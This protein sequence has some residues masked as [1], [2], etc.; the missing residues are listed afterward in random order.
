MLK[1][2]YFIF[3]KKLFVLFII[4]VVAD[5]ALGNLLNYFFLKIKS[6]ETS[7][8]T[9]AINK[10]D[11]RLIVFGSSR[12]IHH[13]EPTVLE[14]S[15][16]LTVYNAG[17]DGQGILYCYGILKSI[18][19]RDTPQKI[20][21]DINL[22]EFIQSQNSYNRLSVLLPYYKTNREVRPVVNLKSRYEKI[23][24]F[25]SLYCYNSL[26][27]SIMLNNLI[28]RNETITKGYQPL[29]KILNKPLKEGDYSA[30]EGNIDTVKVNYFRYFIKDALSANC[31][32]HVFVSPIYY[33]NDSLDASIQIAKQ[34]CKQYNVQVSD[35]SQSPF[36]LK[37]PEY[38]QD[39]S[40][41]NNEGA[42][43]YSSMVS[44][45]IRRQTEI[46]H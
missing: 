2:P 42:K 4:L 28:Q 5:N 16:K 3:F 36:F 37:H 43:I 34:I 6:G 26:V 40:H 46:L 29:F 31:N 9:Y 25:S 20:I 15:L 41:M 18:L 32:V 17:R 8:T 24:T 27:L 11:E 1:N 33:I 10:A 7:R 14:D 44:E 30:D 39:I 38:F 35:Y 19:A 12:A 45:D 22:G 13:Y 21:L 23:K